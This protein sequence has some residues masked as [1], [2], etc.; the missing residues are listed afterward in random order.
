M[1]A[2]SR[3]RKAAKRVRRLD[4]QEDVRQSTYS[5][6][7]KNRIVEVVAG[8]I[9]EAKAQFME[10]FGYYPEYTAQEILK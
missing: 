8:D 10:R 9:E 3:R 1:T 2:K 5:F 7:H 4:R 6:Y